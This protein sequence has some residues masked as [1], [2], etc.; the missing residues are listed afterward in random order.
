MKDNSLEINKY[1]QI[2]IKYQKEGNIH[3]ANEIYRKLINNVIM[4][5]E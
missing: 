5:I 4:M 1:I 3:Q 2:A